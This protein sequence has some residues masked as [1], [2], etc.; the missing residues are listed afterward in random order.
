MFM[1]LGFL[2]LAPLL[3]MISS[4]IALNHLMKL[5]YSKKTRNVMIGVILGLLSLVGLELPVTLTRY[6]M[7]RN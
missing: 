6:A 2:P 4:F 3:S 1:G 7:D 5:Q